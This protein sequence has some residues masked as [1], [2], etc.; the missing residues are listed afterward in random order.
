MCKE[1]VFQYS[2]ATFGT[3]QLC[4]HFLR[5]SS[6]T[7]QHHLTLSIQMQHVPF[8][9]IFYPIRE[10][11]SGSNQTIKTHWLTLEAAIFSYD[12]MD[13]LISH[14]F[15][16]VKKQKCC[17]PFLFLHTC[18][19]PEDFLQPTIKGLHCFLYLA[20]QLEQECSPFLVYLI[21]TTCTF[22]SLGKK[23][24]HAFLIRSAAG[25]F[26]LRLPKY[27]F[28]TWLSSVKKLCF[29]LCLLWLDIPT[30][31]IVER[32]YFWRRW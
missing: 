9:G 7:C 22:S 17:Y 14:H 18:F 15:F 25:R 28:A 29:F 20:S 16:E 13:L 4:S 5:I 6:S 3:R 21:F 24:M 26:L 12:E 32:Q 19:L 30:L 8:S 23:R 2:T 31:I 11:C 1:N 10:S 27:R